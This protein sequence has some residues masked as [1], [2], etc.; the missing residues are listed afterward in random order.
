[1]AL[2]GTGRGWGGS[3]QIELNKNKILPTHILQVRRGIKDFRFLIAGTLSTRWTLQVVH[4]S[5][6]W[7]LRSVQ[8]EHIDLR[9]HVFVPVFSIIFS[10][11]RRINQH[12][13]WNYR[14]RECDLHVTGHYNS[15]QWFLNNDWRYSDQDPLSR[16]WISVRSWKQKIAQFFDLQFS[17][18]TLFA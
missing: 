1:M 16:V 10:L 5:R 11:Q 4:L 14:T 6:F 17:D 12:L 2:V 18:G 9:K 3:L 7:Y 8:M 13:N 15:S